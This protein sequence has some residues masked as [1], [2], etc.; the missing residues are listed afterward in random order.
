MS[1]YG[2]GPPVVR[3]HIELYSDPIPWPPVAPSSEE[4]TGSTAVADDPPAGP[5][6]S[7]PSADHSAEEGTA[8]AQKAAAPLEGAKSTE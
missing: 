5:L 4:A 2:G 7:S 6:N 8:A 3:Q 1:A